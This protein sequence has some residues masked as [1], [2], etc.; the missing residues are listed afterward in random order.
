MKIKEETTCFRQ[1]I[2]E[3]EV[4]EHT[5]KIRFRKDLKLLMAGVTFL[6]F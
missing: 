4:T 3:Q 1:E 2:L 6:F 5:N